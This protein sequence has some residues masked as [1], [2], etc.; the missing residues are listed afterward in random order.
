[1]TALT[2]PS[3]AGTNLT[4]YVSFAL[5]FKYEIYDYDLIQKLY[6]YFDIQLNS[7]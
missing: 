2:D 5:L 6:T 1:M 4:Y 7:I 3:L